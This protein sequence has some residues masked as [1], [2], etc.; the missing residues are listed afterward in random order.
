M[1]IAMAATVAMG[2]LQRSA[3]QRKRRRLSMLRMQHRVSPS[4]WRRRAGAGHFAIF[5]PEDAHAPMAN[6]GR[7][8]HKIVLKVAV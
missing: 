3:R 4:A 5:F 6:P 1:K 8:T 2:G 7:Q